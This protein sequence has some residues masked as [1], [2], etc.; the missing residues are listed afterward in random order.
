[1]KKNHVFSLITFLSIL[2]VSCAESLLP[3]NVGDPNDPLLLKQYYIDEI[4]L[5]DAWKIRGHSTPTIGI[6]D[7]GID[8]TH[9]DLKNMINT[10]LS[11]DFTGLNNP[12]V[13]EVGHGT[14]VAGIIGAEGNNNE[15]ICGINWKSSLVSLKISN[16]DSIF[17]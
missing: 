2:I 4:S 12:F 17:L 9:P 1:M 7:S 3:P 5:R 14:F 6:I 16:S 11:H 8:I 13:D 15:G 10:D